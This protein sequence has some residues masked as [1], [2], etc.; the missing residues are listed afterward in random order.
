MWKIAFQLHKNKSIIRILFWELILPTIS[1]WSVHH[2]FSFLFCLGTHFPTAPQE[3]GSQHQ[4]LRL[5]TPP[6]ADPCHTSSPFSNTLGGLRGGWATRGLLVDL[7]SGVRKGWFPKRW[8][9]RMFPATKNR[10]EGTFAKTAL[11]R[12]RPLASL[13]T[14]FETSPETYV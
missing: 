13:L 6:S 14:Y 4:Q 5:K 3:V 10:N 11:L 8:F 12:N 9:W 2:C 7:F 1:D